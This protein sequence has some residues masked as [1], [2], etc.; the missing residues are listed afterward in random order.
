MIIT[1]IVSLRER[2]EVNEKS[3]RPSTKIKRGVIV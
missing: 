2:L 1:T 3:I